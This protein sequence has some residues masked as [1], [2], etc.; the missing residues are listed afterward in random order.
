MHRTA[1]A[2]RE[3]RTGIRALL[4]ARTVDEADAVE[5]NR[6]TGKTKRAWRTGR[7]AR[8]RGGGRNVQVLGAAP[9]MQSFVQPLILLVE[10]IC[11]YRS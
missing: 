2:D 4:L 9:M 5:G 8:G 7:S 6:R 3:G 1:K 10:A 11:S